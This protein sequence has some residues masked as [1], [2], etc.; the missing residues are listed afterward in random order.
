MRYGSGRF[1]LADQRPEPIVLPERARRCA[2]NVTLGSRE[3]THETNL[4]LEGNDGLLLIGSTNHYE[5]LDPAL[6]GRPSRFD[7]K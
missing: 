5:R 3:R 7:R 4:G 1:G 6:S 2:F